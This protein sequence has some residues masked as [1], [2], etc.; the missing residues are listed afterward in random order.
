VGPEA[1]YE[2][3][4]DAILDAPGLVKNQKGGVGAKTYAVG[5]QADARGAVMEAIQKFDSSTTRSSRCDLTNASV[6][7]CERALN[8]QRYTLEDL[9]KK[10]T[11]FA[12]SPAHNL[13]V[14]KTSTS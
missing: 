3:E 12:T 10:S 13:S 5:H 14:G 9:S 1:Y 11:K 6:C 2:L 8:A 4:I 7:A